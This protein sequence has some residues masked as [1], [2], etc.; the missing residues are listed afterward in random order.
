MFTIIIFRN[1]FHL[2]WLVLEKKLLQVANAFEQG[3]TRGVL[4]KVKV[5]VGGFGVMMF[6][7]SISSGE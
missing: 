5:M 4:L 3:S 7:S 6:C 2:L 1:K